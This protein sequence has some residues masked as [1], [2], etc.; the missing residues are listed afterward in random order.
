VA[1]LVA[2]VRRATR[3]DAPVIDVR[4]F[5]RRQ[6]LA[7]VLTMTAVG[8]VMYSQL[9]SLPLFLHR[10]YGYT[11][12]RQGLLTTALGIGLLFSMSYDVGAVPAPAH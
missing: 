1:S 12:V 10:T 8:F 6:F 7:S 4:L 9:I 2:Y 5:A 3:V 11:G